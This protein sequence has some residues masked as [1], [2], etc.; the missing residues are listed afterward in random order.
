MEAKPLGYDLEAEIR[1][2]QAGRV[3]DRSTGRHLSE[4][5]HWIVQNMDPQRFAGGAVDPIAVHQGFI[6]EDVWDQ[7]LGHQLGNGRQME[8]CEDGIFMTPDQLD[9]DSWRVRE[10]KATKLSAGHPIRGSKFFH[11]HVQV[12]AYCRAMGTLEAELIV[13]HINGS[14]E[15]GGGRFG[16][17]VAR[18][19]LLTFTPRELEENWRMVLRA[20]DQMEE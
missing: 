4:I 20:R 7:V 14:Y 8:M 19:W 2:H 13:L 16:K 12:M 1:R 9:F 17:T 18:P 11:W 15:L 10:F 5:V 6:W 3:R